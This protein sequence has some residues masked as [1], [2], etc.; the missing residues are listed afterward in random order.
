MDFKKIRISSAGIRF[1]VLLLYLV[2][3]S[4]LLANEKSPIGWIEK[5][6]IADHGI[7]LHAKVD[8]GADHSSLN[9][10]GMQLFSKNGESWVEFS[11]TGEN[12]RKI[13]FEKRVVRITKI[14]LQGY[15]SQERPVIQLKLCLS[16]VLKDVEV[17]L[18]DRANF[19]YPLLVGRS[20][21][22]GSFIV[23]VSKEF[24]TAPHCARS[25]DQGVIFVPQ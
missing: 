4:P 1:L 9:A 21:L 12:G 16:D 22:R 8:T 24:T 23:D 17:N 10:D 25:P 15:R 13:A 11:V 3:V 20:F 19:N 18:V 6:A 14:K 2:A 5:V 7:I